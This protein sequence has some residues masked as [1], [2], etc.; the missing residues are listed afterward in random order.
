MLAM[1][2]DLQGR[3]IAVPTVDLR[4]LPAPQKI[5]PLP[6]A[7]NINANE[8]KLN[9]RAVPG[10][11]AY[12]LQIARFGNWEYLNYDQLIYDTSAIADLFGDWPYAWRVR[13]ITVAN[14]CSS[15]GTVDTFSTYESPA[16]L[17]EIGKDM[18]GLLYPNPSE[19]GQTI[20]I[21]TPIGTQV[22]LCNS[23]GQT[24]TKFE[25]STKAE[26]ELK[27]AEAG[28]YFVVFKT[29]ENTFVKR[30]LVQ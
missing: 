15:F 20:L 11:F 13:A 10:A 24:V 23:L 2:N 18:N 6:G 21:K 12:H 30:L 9:W 27:I 5:A 28:I 7:T 17:N 19:I 22:I 1:Q 8:V 14:T 16:S 25:P 3:N 4:S 26:I 29:S